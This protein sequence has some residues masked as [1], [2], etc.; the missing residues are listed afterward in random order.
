MYVYV[1]TPEPSGALHKSIPINMCVCMCIPLSLLV[2]G[3][4]KKCDN[5][6]TRNDRRTVG[7]VVLCAICLVSKGIG[8]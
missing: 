3:Q 1:V 8:D 7:R 2:N 6:Y 5:E 4:L